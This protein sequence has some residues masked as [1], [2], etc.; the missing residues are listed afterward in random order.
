M[1][2]FRLTVPVALFVF[3]R[4]DTT[5]RVFAQI[6]QARPVRLFIIA[7]GP[8]HDHPPDAEG[9]AATRAI[10]QQVDWDCDCTFNYAVGNMGCKTRMATGLDWVFANVEE[11]IILEHDTLPHPDFFRFCQELLALYRHDERI[12][13]I[14][15]CNFQFGQ[16]ATG[17]S[18]YFSRYVHCW[19]WASW[20]RAWRHYDRSISLWPEVRRSGFLASILGHDLGAA[21]WQRILDLT[22]QGYID[23][24]DY[25]WVFSCWSRNALSILPHGN[26]VTN[27]GFGAQGT[28][29]TNASSRVANIPVTAMTFPLQGPPYVLRH[30][31]A[32]ECTQQLYNAGEM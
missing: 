1:E 21:Y 2:D 15:G 11:A 10:V 6:R 18:Y 7:D 4:P 31:A 3:N 25:Q 8:R 24:W 29:T 26:L 16:N 27:I 20:R 17:Y 32:D 12:M 19:G 30:V 28:H 14:G 23:T 9:C 5:T 13:N 22:H